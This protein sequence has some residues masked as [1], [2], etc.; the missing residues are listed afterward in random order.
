MM[1]VVYVKHCLLHSEMLLLADNGA[2]CWLV[3]IKNGNKLK[4]YHW[5]FVIRR[6]RQAGRFP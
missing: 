4:R 2:Y 6:L 5:S 3:A 1:L